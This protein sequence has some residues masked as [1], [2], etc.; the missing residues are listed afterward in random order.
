MHKFYKRKEKRTATTTAKLQQDDY[1]K[2][3][4]DH[5]KNDP[6]ENNYVE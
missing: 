6:H 5:M 4:Y 1:G 2:P 3:V